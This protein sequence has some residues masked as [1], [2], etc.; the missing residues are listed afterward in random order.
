MYNS[1]S[2]PEKSSE[3]LQDQRNQEVGEENDIGE[4]DRL[5]DI[6]PEKFQR[7]FQQWIGYWPKKHFIV[8]RAYDQP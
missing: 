1:I 5:S 6:M 2:P 3:N 8:K 7:F 4:G